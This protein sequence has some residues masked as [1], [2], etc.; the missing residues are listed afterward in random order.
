MK[1]EIVIKHLGYVLLFNGIFLFIA[2]LI[3]YFENET[4]TIPLLF[5]SIITMIFGVLP[6]VFVERTE[7]VNLAEGLAIVVFGWLLTCLVGMLP[8]LMWGGEFTLA[9]AVFESVS[10]YTT[11]GATIL[12]NIEALPKGLL[13]WRSSTHW[14]GGVGIILFVLLILPQSGKSRITIYNAEISSLSKLNFNYKAKKIVQVLAIVYV[15]LTL[16]ETFILM[17]FG[18]SFFDALNHSFATIATG[19]FSTKNTSIAYFHSVGVEITIIVFM[20][21]SGIHFGLLYG[22]MVGDK[23][24]IF[25]SS[26]VRAFVLVMAVGILLVSLK[27]YVGGYYNW[28]NSVRYASFQVASL[29]TT[30]GFATTD[31]A[32]WPIFSQ[33]ILMYFTMQ[34][35]MVGSTSGG[36]KFDRVFIFFKSVS[37]QIKLLKHPNGKFVTKIGRFTIGED[38]ELQTMVFIVL[39]VFTFF[40]TTFILTAMNVDGMTAFSASITTIGNVGP[41]FGKVSSMSNFSSLPDLGKYVLSINM[42]LGRLEIFNIFALIISRKR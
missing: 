6:M 4:S 9:N 33:I 10:G 1:K 12:N 41:G 13:F 5:T 15:S 29:G 42:L 39:Y 11:T 26:V 36:L 22:T 27:L 25:S 35:A 24:N 32:N 37:K 21:L 40:I 18:M 3:S 17:F 20:V 30:T 8:Y 7:T 38:L 16:A 31:T 14:I 23:E 34:C 28:W 2:F 19:G